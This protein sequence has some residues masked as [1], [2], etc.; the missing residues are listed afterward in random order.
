MTNFDSVPSPACPLWIKGQTEKKK[1][2]G[3]FQTR[4]GPHFGSV[5]KLASMLSIQTSCLILGPHSFTLLIA[6]PCACHTPHLPGSCL[7]FLRHSCLPFL[8]PPWGQSLRDR[9]RLKAQAMEGCPRGAWIAVCALFNLL[10]IFVISK[11]LDT[12]LALCPALSTLLGCVLFVDTSHSV[13]PV[14]TD[15]SSFFWFC[16]QSKEMIRIERL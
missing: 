11:I 15:V 2:E 4:K 1:G 9:P 3:M 10:T 7:L 16:M 6:S 14:Q 12:V 8:L 13:P 5:D